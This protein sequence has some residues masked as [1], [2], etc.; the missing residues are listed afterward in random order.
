MAA[1]RNMQPEKLAEIESDFLAAMKTA[2]QVFG[3][4]AFR[5]RYNRGENRRKPV[6]KALFESWSVSLAKLTDAQ[7]KLLVDRKQFLN[8][9][10]MALLNNSSDFERSISTGTGEKSKVTH[11]F[12]EV[13]KLI[14][15][16][17]ND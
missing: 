4:H 10:A 14:E 15:A 11:R 9:A 3:V 17:L 16:T 13:R 2:R 8:D 1:L 7:R 5:K 12:E 6:N